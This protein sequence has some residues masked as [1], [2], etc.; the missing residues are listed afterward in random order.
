MARVI[1]KYDLA[2]TDSQT[3]QRVGANP[4]VRHFAQQ[5][6]RLR[7][8]VEHDLEGVET[9]SLE[10]RGTGHPVGEVGE[11]IGT[12]MTWDGFVWHLYQSAP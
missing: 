7:V 2:L 6:G 12:V 3:I 9:L 11:F 1:Y 4:V 5:E 8:W 10:L